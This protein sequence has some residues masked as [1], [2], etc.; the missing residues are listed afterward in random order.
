MDPRRSY[1][2]Y[3]IAVR[4]E[5]PLPCKPQLA[6]GPPDV[7][8]RR[9]PARTFRR[10]QSADTSWFAHQPQGDGSD[11]LRWTGL[12]EFLVS[13]DGR[14]IDGRA[15]RGSSAGVFD[16]FLANQIL[17]FA[18][19]KLGLEPLHATTVVVNHQAVAFLGDCGEGKST[20]GAAFVRA[21]DRLLT[22]DQLVIKAASASR[23]LAYPGLPRL[24]LFPAVARAVLGTA[25]GHPLNP[26]TKKLVI[27]LADGSPDQTGP[28]PLRRLYCLRSRPTSRRITIR[29]LGPRSASV[30]LIQHTF[31]PVILTPDRLRQQ[32]GWVTRLA[33]AV[34]VKSVTYPRHLRKLPA[35]RDAIL[36]DLRAG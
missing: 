28:V 31:N 10:F 9:A 12:F 25:D 32:F 35:V 15:L 17:S 36:Q 1:H 2:V 23:F 33:L 11:Y 6:N 18:L 14:R 26:L 27:R 13:A 19:L 30:A 22:D 29:S 20:M 8:I 16:T 34:P 5:F 4:S 24:K 3:G 7:E 21:G